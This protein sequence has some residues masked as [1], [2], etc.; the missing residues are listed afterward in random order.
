MLTAIQRRAI[1]L[2]F[3]LTDEEIAEKLRISKRMLDEWKRSPD[4]ANAICDYV[5]ENRRTALRL[6]SERYVE[7]A[8]ELES[9][10][11]SEDEKIKYKAIIDLLKASNLLKDADVH[12]N[13]SI[14]QILRQIE[15]KESGEDDDSGEED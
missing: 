15:A 2:L 9:L 13:D 3:R 8:R 11:K 14:E 4:F 1:P 5:K 7:A 10:I 6:L 12:E